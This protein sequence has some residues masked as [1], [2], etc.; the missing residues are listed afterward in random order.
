[1]I[2]EVSGAIAAT[3]KSF[4]FFFAWNAQM[5]LWLWEPVNVFPNKDIQDQNLNI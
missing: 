5:K 2:T 4:L 3:Q 1:M